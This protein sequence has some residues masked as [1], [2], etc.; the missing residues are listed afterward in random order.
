MKQRFCLVILIAFGLMGCM[1]EDITQ[2]LFLERDGTATW[3]LLIEHDPATEPEEE[4]AKHSRTLAGLASGDNDYMGIMEEVGAYDI[5]YRILRDQPP[6]VYEVRGTLDDLDHLLEALLDETP[7][8]WEAEVQDDGQL[9]HFWLDP[10]TDRG[11][12]HPMKLVVPGGSIYR[13]GKRQ[14]THVHLKKP[15]D[16]HD[17]TVFWPNP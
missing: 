2:T 15:G 16:W 12:V 7:A 5:D 17:L 4:K 1:E 3:S 6:L 8:Y 11:E 10:N 9:L 13:K 14:K